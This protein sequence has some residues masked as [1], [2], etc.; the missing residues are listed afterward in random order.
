M[1]DGP[2]PYLAA[3]MQSSDR[4]RRTLCVFCVFARD[5]FCEVLVKT[6]LFHFLLADIKLIV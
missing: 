5:Y 4:P 3:P 6:V 1:T 2:Y